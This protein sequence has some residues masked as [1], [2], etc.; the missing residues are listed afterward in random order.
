MKHSYTILGEPIPLLRNRISYLKRVSYD[1]QKEIKRYIAIELA[2]QHGD[3]PM[4]KAPLKF[5]VTY[6]M[7]IAESWSKKKTALYDGKPHH[8]RCDLDN[9]VK[10]SLDA[11][12]KV[13]YEDDAIIAII[14]AKKVFCI[15]NPRTEFTLEE[16]SL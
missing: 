7:P 2:Y 9:L 15:T 12:N 6:Y 13:L 14:D 16:I 3:R 5:T 11:A 4:F 1:S 10:M 8:I